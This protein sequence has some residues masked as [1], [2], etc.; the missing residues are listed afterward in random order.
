MGA[1]KTAR[2]FPRPRA[3]IARKFPRRSGHFG[4]A[5]NAQIISRW[6]ALARLF[7][8]AEPWHWQRQKSGK[9]GRNRANRRPAETAAP[10]GPKSRRLRRNGRFDR[11]CHDRPKRKKRDARGLKIEIA[12]ALR[13][14][15]SI[16]THVH[17]WPV[18][19]ALHSALACPCRPVATGRK[20]RTFVATF[21][22]SLRSINDHCRR[23]GPPYEETQGVSPCFYA[24][25]PPR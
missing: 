19:R 21:R 22:R 15:L 23:D 17:Y 8:H 7:A 4:D 13:G 2:Y 9:I 6:R 3:V 14:Q 5:R 16:D 1:R 12:P 24:P 18:N 10:R 20:A 11:E 25:A